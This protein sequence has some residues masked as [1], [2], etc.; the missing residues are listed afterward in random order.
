M[1]HGIALWLGHGLG[2][3]RNL[4]CGIRWMLSNR[5]KKNAWKL[6]MLNLVVFFHKFRE[7]LFSICLLYISSLDLF[8]S[9]NL[10]TSWLKDPPSNSVVTS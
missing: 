2:W 4:R 1:S 6:E 9:Y 7:P 8:T 10:F 3:K 5:E